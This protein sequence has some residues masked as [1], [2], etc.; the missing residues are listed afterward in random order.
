MSDAEF[1]RRAREAAK[2][3]GLAAAGL[4]D[5]APERDQVF[6]HGLGVIMGPIALVGKELRRGRLVMPWPEPALRSR[7]YFMHMP[8]ARRDAPAVAALRL[9]L[10][11]AGQRA[12]AEYPA[13]LAARRSNRG[14][15]RRVD[16]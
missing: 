6:E 12:E 14:A 1:H 9:W 8:E 13:Y 5:L 10:L 7:G 4:P 3:R 11:R 16:A 2:T 15:G